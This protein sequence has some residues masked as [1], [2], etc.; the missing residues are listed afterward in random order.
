MARSD[1]VRCQFFLPKDVGDRFEAIVSQPGVSKSAVF[2]EAL[3]T[4]LNR[5][6]DDELELRFAKRLDQS[7]KQLERIERKSR[8]IQEC[9]T[10]FIRYMLSVAEPAAARDEGAGAAGRERFNAFL[11]RVREQ[12]ASVGV[13]VDV[14]SLQ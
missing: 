7:S 1:K 4:F 9:L 6:G 3:T 2:E 14:G 12:L 11:Q 13:N 5:K 8:V 10:L